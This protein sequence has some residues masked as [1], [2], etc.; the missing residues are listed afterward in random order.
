MSI[1]DSENT[2]RAI[3]D[4]WCAAQGTGWRVV[5]T[6]G[7]GGTAPVF[8]LETPIGPRAL[9][10]LDQGYSTGALREESI[11]RITIQITEIGVHDCPYLVK[12]FD[13]GEFEDR[14]FLLMNRAPGG[15]L[16]KVLDVIPRE[17]IANIVDQVARACLFLR[18]RGLCHRD[19][20]SENIFVTDDFNQA[21]LLDVSVVRKV[22]DPLGLG[23]DHG[24]SLPVVATSRYTPPEYLFRLLEPSEELWH[25][26]DVYQL[27]CLIHDLVMRVQIFHDEYQRASDNRYRFAWIVATK[28]PT[29]SASDVDTG[30]ILL[31]Q[32]AVDKNWQRRSALRIEDFL[33]EADSR[34]RLGLEAIGLLPREKAKEGLA[35]GPLTLRTVLSHHAQEL[36]E[37]VREYQVEKG[38]TATHAAFP[39]GDDLHWCVSF[40]WALP[41]NQAGIFERVKL[42]YELYLEQSLQ[43]PQIAMR[44]RLNAGT[45]SG[46]KTVTLELPPV[47]ID[48]ASSGTLFSNAIAAINDLAKQLMNNPAEGN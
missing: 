11:R 43:D 4:R 30:L 22:Y 19:I 32:R 24:N 3:A 9:K 41:G 35:A 27:G 2:N 13:G 10:L 16:T 25:A 1:S 17:K 20:K 45:E 42:S 44:A 48:D 18:H 28:T 29:I 12:V 39:L 5:D 40:D 15:E 47:A 36:K 8:E 46:E 21:T 31:G 26:V 34:S 37:A 38:I 7:R 23:T 33:Q 14:L 6:A